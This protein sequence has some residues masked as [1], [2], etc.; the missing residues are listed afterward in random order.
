M[1]EIDLLITAGI[2]T[3]RGVPQKMKEKLKTNSVGG[4]AP[5]LFLQK[6]N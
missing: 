1:V 6:K 4:L 2:S 3:N 5:L